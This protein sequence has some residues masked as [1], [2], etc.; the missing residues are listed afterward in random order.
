MPTITARCRRWWWEAAAG[1][2]KEGSTCD[3]PIV[4]TDLFPTL[5]EAAGIDQAKTVGP[6]DG[7]SISKLLRGESLQERLDGAPG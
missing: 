1:S 3:T 6:V 4:L 2:S 5:L 7:I